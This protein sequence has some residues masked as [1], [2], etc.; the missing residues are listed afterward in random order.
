MPYRL[1]QECPQCSA[2]L[3]IEDT[4]RLISCSFCG[5][6]SYLAN[7]EKCRLVLPAR[8]AGKTNLHV[9]YLHFKGAV[10]GCDQQS[11]KFRLADT[12]RLAISLP[13]VPSSLGVRPQAMKMRYYSPAQGSVLIK[14]TLTWKKVLATM[15]PPPIPRKKCLHQV[16]IGEALN[17]IYLPL[18]LKDTT[19]YDAILDR[20]LGTVARGWDAIGPQ[21]QSR[22]GWQPRFLA[23]LCPH[24]GW[25]LHG[26]RDSV[27]LFCD[28]CNSAWTAGN[29]RL[30][31]VPFVVQASNKN[32]L[33]LPF[34]QILATA[35]GPVAI[36]SF[37]DFIRITNQ[38]LVVR[39]GWKKQ[40]MRFYA[41]AFKIRPKSFLRLATRATV[42]QTR[43]T[44]TGADMAD[45]D[46]HPVTLP[47]SEAIQALKIILAN[48]ALTRKNIFPFLP[49]IRFSVQQAQLALLPFSASSHEFIQE[50]SG[51]TVNRNSLR[52]GRGL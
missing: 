7:P 50:Q 31:R 14:N 32:S 40:P 26:A 47:G 33:Y 52:F 1:E 13:L 5:V 25:N 42:S 46:L 36:D 15:V 44:L 2:P 18:T 17:V 35:P 8:D 27:V 6:S 23:S 41:P 28:H 39:P 11:V 29:N 3:E 20:P 24:C 30:T 49:E 43:F 38:P 51:I 9:P 22:A 48:S 21:V 10:Y 37:A 12:T 19:L 4:D 34:W 45:I 16:A